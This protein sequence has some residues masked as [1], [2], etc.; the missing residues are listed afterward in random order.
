MG[1]QDG[2]HRDDEKNYRA[3]ARFFTL[4]LAAI[5]ELLSALTVWETT[6]GM[7]AAIGIINYSSAVA[8]RVVL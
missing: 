6:I 8:R 5:V 2:L 7:D 3:L 4:Q 1:R